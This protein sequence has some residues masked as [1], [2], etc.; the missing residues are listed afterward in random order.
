MFRLIRK[1]DGRT[2][3][4]QFEEQALTVSH[5]VKVIVA[6]ILYIFV[7]IISLFSENITRINLTLSLGPGL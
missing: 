2:L 1:E 6:K 5:R 3:Q 4:F 7:I